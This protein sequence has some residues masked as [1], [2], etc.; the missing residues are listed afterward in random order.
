LING[1]LT[2]SCHS[3]YMILKNIRYLVTQNADRQILE[4][5]DVK[6]SDNRISAI[7]HD[8]STDDEEVLDCSDKVVMPG[9]INAHTHVSMTLLRGISDDL[10]LDDWLHDVIFPAEEKL[11]AED[12][13]V[14]AKL[15]CLEMLK[16]G[17]TTFN[18]MYD[19]MDQVAKAVEEVGMRAV[20]SR[21]VLDVDGNGDERMAEPLILL[22]ITVSMTGLLLVLRLMQFILLRAMFSLS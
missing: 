16:S 13:Y 12:A 22:L 8:L 9:L 19:H 3:H 5:I 2:F 1:F 20:L 7:G 10:E 4:N 18:D 17:T 11:N 14:G 6:T 15:G 21:G